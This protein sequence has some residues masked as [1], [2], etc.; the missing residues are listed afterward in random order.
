MFIYVGTLR[1]NLWHYHAIS[2]RVLC[3]A[4]NWY[5]LVS[6]FDDCNLRCN[7]M[8][9]IKLVNALDNSALPA[10]ASHTRKNACQLRREMNAICLAIDQK[11][12]MNFFSRIKFYSGINSS[13]V[14][15]A[16]ISGFF[17]S[18][19]HVC[20]SWGARD[21]HSF[22]RYIAFLFD[23]VYVCVCTL[24]AP[25][26]N[27]VQKRFFKEWAKI[28]TS[29]GI[30]YQSFDEVSLKHVWTM[31]TFKSPHKIYIYIAVTLGTLKQKKYF[32]YFFSLR[33][34]CYKRCNG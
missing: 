26:R 13:S 6:H 3:S 18:V 23:F 2:H 12:K 8:N 27:T 1:L 25:I 10:T 29:H 30:V 4:F 11:K 33:F 34:P 24:C 15:M 28:A 5:V 20:S 32:K 9:G 17:F 19:I 16:A 31:G 7:M 21:I 14:S 22:S